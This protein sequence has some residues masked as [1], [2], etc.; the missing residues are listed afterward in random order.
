MSN[1]GVFIFS[2][3]MEVWVNLLIGFFFIVIFILCINGSDFCFYVEGGVFKSNVL[4]NSVIG[5]IFVIVDK[6][7]YVLVWYNV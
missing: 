2:F 1:L 4:I 7:N 6:Y 3:I 5:I